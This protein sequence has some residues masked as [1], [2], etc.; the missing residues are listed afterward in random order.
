[1]GKLIPYHKGDE[2][3]I[4]FVHSLMTARELVHVFA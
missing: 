4:C 2:N 3:E 1:M